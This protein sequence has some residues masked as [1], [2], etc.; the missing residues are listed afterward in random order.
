MY[1][2]F[3][4]IIFSIFSFAMLAGLTVYGL[5]HRQNVGVNE[6]IFITVILAWWVFC[7]AFELMALT[8]PVKLF[9]AN[10]E[11][12]GSALSPFAYLTLTM[13]FSGKGRFLTR[14]NIAIVLIIYSVFLGLLFTDGYHGLMRTNFSLDTSAVPYTISKDY[15]TLYPIYVLFTY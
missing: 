13:R 3:P 2:F 5:K 10:I 7:Q 6:F 12:F 1:Q 15:S 14:K 8:L 11:H 4:Y 9:W